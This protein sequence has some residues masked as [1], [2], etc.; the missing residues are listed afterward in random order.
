MKT[1]TKPTLW[2]ILA[3]VTVIIIIGSVWYF[4]IRPISEEATT[5]GSKFIYCNDYEFTCCAAY[6][7]PVSATIDRVSRYECPNNAIYC[8]ID[9]ASPSPYHI[10]IGS[11][12]C[13]IQQRVENL[14]IKMWHCDD[15]QEI[16][17]GKEVPTGFSVW[18]DRAINAHF[19]VKNQKLVFTGR[20]ANV[21]G[22]VTIKSDSCVFNPGDPHNDGKIYSGS[23]GI[24]SNGQTS[25]TVP[26]G[27]CVLS[28]QAGDRHICGDVDERCSIDTDCVGHTYGNK[29]C[30]A[31]TLQTYGC[32]QL[33]LP[34]GITKLIDGYFGGDSLISNQKK[35][36]VV[37]A[38]RCEIKS[39]VPVQCCGDTDCGSNMFCDKT[40][41]TC[42]NNVGC[43][44]D[45]YCGVSTQCKFDTL[46][47]VKPACVAGQCT[48]QKVKDIS[49]CYDANCPVGYFCN[50]DYTCEQSSNS[51][52]ICPFEC[53]DG[54]KAYFDRA[55]PDQKYC[56]NH[57]C[58]DAPP[59]PTDCKKYASY[60]PRKYWCYFTDW[61][62][63]VGKIIVIILG[64][65]GGLIGILFGYSFTKNVAKQERLIPWVVALV[66]AVACFIL[67]YYIWWTFFIILIVGGAGFYLTKK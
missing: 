50:N 10:Y 6:D 22:G 53:C 40:T 42:K 47:L 17:V 63:E 36:G 15:Q 26:A 27:E 8:K 30:Y 18:S 51:T 21:Q 12:N 59:P 16:T 2:I 25:Y 43:T 65:L 1:K 41:F 54:E 62:T 29:E 58:Q 38:S 11:K 33:P 64:L 3:F 60:D 46:E 44:S 7:T 9:Q 28:W 24:L 66:L 34:F 4:K 23:G 57:A 37:P 45:S 61:L 56:V 20:A 32:T 13:Q 49:C 39:A 48:Y 14:F 35:Y 31:R 19:Q 5:T 52:K 55:C 67:I